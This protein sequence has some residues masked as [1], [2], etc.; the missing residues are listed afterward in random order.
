MLFKYTATDIKTGII[1][2]EI[3]EAETLSDLMARLKND[4]L[5]NIRAE[6]LS[7][8]KPKKRWTALRGKISKKEVKVFTRQLA[9][10]LGAGFLLTQALDSVAEDMKNAHFGN[11]IKNVRDDVK[12]GVEF[13]TALSKYPQVFPKSYTAIVKS[14]E[15]T[16]WLHKTL[17][18]LAQYLEDSERLKEKVKTAVSYPIFV[19][20]FTVFVVLGIVLFII[21]RFKS[22]FATLDTELP[23]LTQV[24]VN[25]SEFLVQHIAVISGCVVGLLVICGILLRFD[26]VRQKA[27]SLK[28]KIPI[29]GEDI[30]RKSLIVRFCYT[31][32]FLLEGGVP[33]A[34][35]LSITSEVVSHIPLQ[36]SILEIKDHVTSGGMISEKVKDQ[37]IYP[38]LVFKMI[39]LGEKSGKL[40][41]M[42][43][44]T[45]KYY[46]DEIEFSIQRLTSMLEPMLIVFVG[47][48]VFV[49]VIALYLPIFRI[50]QVL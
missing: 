17:G 27:D 41:E 33:L 15:A 45:A 24:V 21:P 30:L 20:S 47:G 22:I 19:L 39:S 34:Q 18:D 13:S 29:I 6:R 16:G 42:L 10:T 25:V 26:A 31:L 35:S 36:K 2:S 37:K 23:M 43:K 38:N 5:K 46:E 4:G 12:S 44:R 9:A 7:L 48:I 28:I 50:V 3:A 32:G 1:K 11:V 14:G 49:V 40:T 8:E